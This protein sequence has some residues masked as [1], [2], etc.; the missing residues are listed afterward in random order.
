MGGHY[1][2]CHDP[3]D[4]WCEVRRY[5]HLLFIAAIIVCIQVASGLYFEILSLAAD[6]GHTAT[7]GAGYFVALIAAVL[8]R[9]GSD[10]R[11]VDKKASY[12]VIGLLFL[13]AFSIVYEAIDRLFYNEKEITGWIMALG[14][15]IGFVGNHIE[16]HILKHTADEHKDKTHESLSFH[17]IT[18][19]ALSIIVCAGGILNHFTGWASVDPWASLIIAFWIFLGA[20]NLIKKQSHVHKNM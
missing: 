6:G 18:D 8:M 5:S 11:S 16:R 14:G 15:F 17:V 4:C 19:R 20:I 13:A 12:I 3:A 10:R 9:I 2:S 1:K 7:H